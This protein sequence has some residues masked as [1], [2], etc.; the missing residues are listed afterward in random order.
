M[1]HRYL[2]GDVH[3]GGGRR[4]ETWVNE[5]ETR[6]NEPETRRQGADAR[7]LVERGGLR[8]LRGHV[9]EFQ[10]RAIP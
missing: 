7:S 4:P 6:V 1:I 2:I 9:A 8:G 3:L 10:I 5:P